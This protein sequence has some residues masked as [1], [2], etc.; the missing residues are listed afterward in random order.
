VEDVGE[1]EGSKPRERMNW[2]VTI[3]VNSCEWRMWLFTPPSLT[4]SA[5]SSASA[6]GPIGRDT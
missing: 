6:T 1:M 5:S 3:T 4:H 2:L